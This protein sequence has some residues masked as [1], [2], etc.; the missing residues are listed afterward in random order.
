[1]KV[2]MVISHVV[3]GH[4]WAGDE[5]EITEDELEVAKTAIKDQIGNLTYIELGQTIIPADLIR[6][7]CV[8][9]FQTS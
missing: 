7:H 4:I 2:K 6:Q 5:T 9:T 3:S 8:I 1:M